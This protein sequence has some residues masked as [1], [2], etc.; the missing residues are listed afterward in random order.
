MDAAARVVVAPDARQGAY[1]L[2]G[3]DFAD[4]L[5]CVV[6]ATNAGGTVAVAS[7]DAIGP[8]GAIALRAGL[9]P[10]S[11]FTSVVCSPGRCTARLLVTDDAPPAPV[12]VDARVAGRRMRVRALGSGRYALTTPRLARGRH[13]LTVT[14]TDAQ[15]D[16]QARAATVTV[17]VR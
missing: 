13:R 10:A 4:A 3:A 8:A 7:G 6:R 17:R 16:R 11:R 12:R 2:T 1:R 9:A 15:G 5:F 14:V